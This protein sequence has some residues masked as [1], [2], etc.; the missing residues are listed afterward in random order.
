MGFEAELTNICPFIAGP[1]SKLTAVYFMYTTMS[2]VKSW[3]SET[4][5]N[6]LS[7]QLHRYLVVWIQ[8]F[9]APIPG[10]QVA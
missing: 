8:S 2:I 1:S 9:C 6:L 3:K 5:N 4:E 7:K 10:T